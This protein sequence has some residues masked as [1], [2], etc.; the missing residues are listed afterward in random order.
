MGD[1]CMSLKTRTFDRSCLQNRPTTR[2]AAQVR[3]HATAHWTWLVVRCNAM[4][5]FQQTDVLWW[6]TALAI[7]SIKET[8]VKW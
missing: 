1:F 4:Y 7:S 2:H 6:R 5:C 8:F 3:M